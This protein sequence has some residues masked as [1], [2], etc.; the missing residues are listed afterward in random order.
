MLSRARERALHLRLLGGD[1]AAVYHCSAFSPPNVQAALRRRDR[2]TAHVHMM[3]EAVDT[4]VFDYAK[5]PRSYDPSR[6]S[7]LAY[8]R[9]AAW[10]AFLM[11]LEREQ[12]RRRVM[13]SLPAVELLPDGG[14]DPGNDEPITLPPGVT[15]GGVLAKP[16]RLALNPG[17]QRVIRLMAVDEVRD[18]AVFARVLGLEHLDAQGQ[19]DAVKHAKDRLTK[20]L[21]RLGERPRAAAS[22]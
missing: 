3:E 15:P 17:D 13:F 16:A 11:L 19:E 12:R 14:N 4:D 22:A 2:R 9:M 18:T 7:L 5:S 10:R 6:L 1:A 20:R 21:R 8:P